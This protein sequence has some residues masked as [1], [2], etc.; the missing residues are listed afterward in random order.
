MKLTTVKPRQVTSYDPFHQL[1]N[2]FFPVS[3]ISRP[4]SQTSRVATNILEFDDYF[5]LQLAIPGFSK[6][7]FVIEIK[8]DQLHVSLKQNENEVTEENYRSREFNY[9]SLDRYWNLSDQIDQST[10]KAQY[11]HGILKLTLVKKEEAKKQA[12]RTIE[13]L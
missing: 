7:D 3:R 4:R 8:D 12:P 2:E 11:E 5:E 9:K 1:V 6:D 10:V 13:I